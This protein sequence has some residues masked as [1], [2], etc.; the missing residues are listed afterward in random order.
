MKPELTNNLEDLEKI[1]QYLAQFLTE[2]RLQKS[3]IMQRKVR[4]SFYL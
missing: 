1:F 2:E 3:T 4:I